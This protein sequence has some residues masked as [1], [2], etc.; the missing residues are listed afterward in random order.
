M[1]KSSWAFGGCECTEL[2]DF[3]YY[4]CSVSLSRLYFTHLPLTALKKSIKLPRYILWSR[5]TCRVDC[6][7]LGP[8][9]GQIWAWVMAPKGPFFSE[10]LMGLKKI[11]EWTEKTIYLYFSSIFGDFVLRFFDKEVSDY[12]PL[13]WSRYLAII[14]EFGVGCVIYFWNLHSRYG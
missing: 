8:G 3:R 9:L 10:N 6:W 11:K 14:C 4:Q 5:L 2:S 13:I 7:D 1:M 12:D